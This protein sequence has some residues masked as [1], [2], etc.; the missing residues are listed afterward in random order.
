MPPV[1]ARLANVKALLVD[2]DDDA[3][4]MLS[5]LLGEEGARV[6][7]ANS[8]S[9]AIEAFSSF[10][11]DVVISDI[12]MPE[13]DGYDLVRAIRAQEGRGDA[14]PIIA[15]SAMTRNQDRV[16]AREAGFSEY[17]NKPVDREQLIEALARLTRNSRRLAEAASG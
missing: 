14:V 6:Q 9:A 7:A 5:A 17:L 11:P 1:N 2:D 12:A 4:D 8:T 13:Q 3:R 15:L 16:R 10:A